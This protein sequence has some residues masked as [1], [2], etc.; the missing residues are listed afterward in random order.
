VVDFEILRIG[1]EDEFH[2]ML[3]IFELVFNDTESFGKPTRPRTQY[4]QSMILN[5]DFIGLLAKDRDGHAM[6]A[7]AAYVLRKFEQERSEIY[8]YDLAVHSSVRRQGA[9]TAL[10]RRLVRIAREIGSYVIF[11]QADKGAEDL[12]AQTLYRKLG[13][14][15][16]VFHYDLRMDLDEA[17]H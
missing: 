15:E 2:Q 14:E 7:L 8:I 10:I 1:S 13:V 11:V 6:G 4:I 16:D 17:D 3:D 5:Q 12:P 9:A